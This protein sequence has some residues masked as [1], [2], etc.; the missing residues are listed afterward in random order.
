MLFFFFFFFLVPYIESFPVERNAYAL[1]ARLVDR[2]FATFNGSVVADL[3]DFVRVHRPANFPAHLRVLDFLGWGW[4]LSIMN[5]NEASP[6]RP[7]S[8]ASQSDRSRPVSS[9]DL[10]T[11]G[12]QDHDNDSD[13]SESSSSSSLPPVPESDSEPDI[14]GEV[15]AEPVNGFVLPRRAPGTQYLTIF[16]LATRC[17]IF[18]VVSVLFIL[19]FLSSFQSLS[20]T[21]IGKIAFPILPTL[22]IP[23]S[24]VS[25][26]VHSARSRN[27]HC[28]IVFGTFIFS[29]YPFQSASF[30]TLIS[31][32]PRSSPVFG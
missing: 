9:N 12:A 16:L 22:V 19:P 14:G 24:L 13:S 25:A 23:M 1:L 31:R 26:F 17:L 20:R 3:A 28:S 27:S 11:P 2:F 30:V 15:A 21:Y 10:V 7:V 5:D 18:V 4:N 8:S 6:S 32:C 29:F